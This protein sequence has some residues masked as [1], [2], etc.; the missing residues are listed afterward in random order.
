MNV[1]D[2]QRNKK[3]LIQKALKEHYEFDIN[4][5]AM[6]AEKTLFMLTKVRGLVKESLTKLKNP[7]SDRGYLK[8]IMMKQLLETHYKDVRVAHRIIVENEEVQKSQ[9]ILAAQDMIDEMQKMIERVSKMNAE[10][11]PAVVDGISNEIGTNES[12]QFQQTT[13]EALSGLQA[14]L[15][16]AKNNLSGAL[17]AITGGQEMPT[18]FDDQ[19]EMDQPEMDQSDDTDDISDQNLD[20]GDEDTELPELPEPE[21]TGSAGRERR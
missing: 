7:S 19:S 5:S 10:E 1:G 6:N 14:A 17:S 8:L 11:L 2:F 12:Q 3:Q 21:S 20:I 9:V 13:S 16:D 15:T 4:L 18:A